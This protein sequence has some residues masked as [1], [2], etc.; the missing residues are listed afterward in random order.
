MLGIQNLKKAAA[1]GL[2][3][4][5]EIQKA[6]ADGFTWTDSFGFIDEIAQIPGLLQSGNEIV[7]E[8]KDLTDV[9]KNELVVYLQAEFDIPDDKV[10]AIVEDAL[11]LALTIVA[12][13]NKWKTT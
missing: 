2:N 11:N 1:F 3:L 4:A 12:L 10:E 13:I 8:F 6:G 5:E 7:A 9:E